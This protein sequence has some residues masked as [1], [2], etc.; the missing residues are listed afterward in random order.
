MTAAMVSRLASFKY[1]LYTVTN[2][3][4]DISHP[5]YYI[6]YKAAVLNLLLFGIS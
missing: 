6:L 5:E 4:I 1:S 3:H 2:F